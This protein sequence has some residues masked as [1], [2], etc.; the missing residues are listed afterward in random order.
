MISTQENIFESVVWKNFGH[1][2]QAS[3]R[4]LTHVLEAFMKM[5]GPLY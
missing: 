3:V 2:F 4:T 1:F 5:Q